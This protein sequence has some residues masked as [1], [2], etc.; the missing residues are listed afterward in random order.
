[1]TA[2]VTVAVTA[3]P[4]EPAPADRASA[5]RAAVRRS[6]AHARED[7]SRS[8][9]AEVILARHTLP[10]T[11]VDFLAELECDAAEQSFVCARA[12]VFAGKAFDTFEGL[13][14]AVGRTVRAPGHDGEGIAAL[15]AAFAAQHR[16][17]ALVA[18]DRGAADFHAAGDL[19]S[20]ARAYLDAKRQPARELARID[21]WLQGTELLRAE[22]QPVAL[23]ALS[24]RTAK[25]SLAEI[26]LLVRALGWRGLVVIFEDAE[27]ITKLPP[28]RRENAYT[29]LRELIDN[30]DTARGLVSVQIL[31]TGLPPLFEGRRS[32]ESLAPLALRVRDASDAVGAWPPPHRPRID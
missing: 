18:F 13:V 15:L 9:T 30:T 17:A 20:L 16:R 4:V 29:V 23:G 31:V 26:S 2:A 7:L 14:R 28:G 10:S 21:A 8:R 25:R 6:L 5:W 12:A 24:P 27:V 32:I 22:T 11:G 19:I 3:D 1:M